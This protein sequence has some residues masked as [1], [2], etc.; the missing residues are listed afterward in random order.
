MGFGILHYVIICIHIQILFPNKLQ[1]DALNHT[2]TEA[3]QRYEEIIDQV[4]SEGMSVVTPEITSD[5]DY[6]QS[7]FFASTVLTTIGRTQTQ[8]LNLQM[9]Q[10]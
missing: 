5:W 1:P 3:L 9:K 10:K 6:I 7:A 4:A 2:L 8:F